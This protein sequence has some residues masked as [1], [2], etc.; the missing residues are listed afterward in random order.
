MSASAV[1][2]RFVREYTDWLREK[3]TVA[4]VNGSFEITT[5]FL[6]RHNDHIQLYVVPNDGRYRLTDDGYVLGDLESGGCRID[7]PARKK[8]L[9]V[10]LAGFGVSHKSG[11][12]YIDADA[13]DFPR[14]KHAILQAMLAVNDMFMTAK[15]R[16][17]GMFIEDVQKFFETTGVRYIPSVEFTGR[18]GYSHKFDFAI[19]KSQRSPERLIRAINTPTRETATLLI[20]AWTDT[21]G[22]REENTQAYAILND[23]EKHLGSDVL[24]SFRQYGVRP[25]LWTEREQVIKEFAA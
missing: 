5:P 2:D 18:S 17:A 3:T 14:K 8:L 23:E 20:F 9:E 19:P 22:V 1:S 6:D 12:L 11:E 25:V 7:S 21:K 16:V 13:G 4:E 24:N 15:P 10:T